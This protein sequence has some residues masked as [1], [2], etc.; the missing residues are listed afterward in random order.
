MFSAIKA[1]SPSAMAIA[2]ITAVGWLFLDSW[3]F[4]SLS[5]VSVSFSTLAP[6]RPHNPVPRPTTSGAG[7]S[8][9][10]SAPTATVPRR[11]AYSAS[12]AQPSTGDWP[13][14]GSMRE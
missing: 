10:C 13:S 3:D 4:G 8:R 5:D 11:R 7:S 14:S 12:V 9:H 6:V 2:T 1:S